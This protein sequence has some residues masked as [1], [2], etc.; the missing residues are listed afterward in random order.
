MRRLLLITL[1]TMPIGGCQY[2]SAGEDVAIID[3]I[4]AVGDIAASN[5]SVELD[6]ETFESPTVE[7]KPVAV[8]TPDLIRSTDPDARAK[9]IDRSRPDPFASL[10]IPPPPEPVELPEAVISSGESVANGGSRGGSRGSSNGGGGGTSGTTPVAQPPSVP[11]PTPPPVRVQPNNEPLV[12]PSPIAALP[13][14]PQPVIAPTVSVSGIIQ[15]GGEP[16]AIVSA[17]NE[18]E[19]YVRVG[20]RIAGGSVRVK[21]IDTLA[22]EPRVILEENGIEVSR[23]ISSGA[24]EN[25]SEVAEPVPAVPAVPEP[26]AAAIPSTAPPSQIPAA[27]LSGI[28]IP[29]PPISALRSEAGFVP[30]SLL[31]APPEV[32]TQATLPSMPNGRNG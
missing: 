14:I 7:A 5:G 28:A 17:G 16:Y 1:A 15:L 4:E 27:T 10:P 11:E 23:P 19:R 3:P 32:E 30:G 25:S 8:I 31:L 18:P 20:D 29:A 26:V 21:R 13:R 24:E 9:Q 22:F 12:T 2:L 6:A